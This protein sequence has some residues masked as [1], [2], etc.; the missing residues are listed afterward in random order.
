MKTRSRLGGYSHPTEVV[1]KE[2]VRKKRRGCTKQM[3]RAHSGHAGRPR[4]HGHCSEALSVH[5][6]LNRVTAKLPLA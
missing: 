2:L 6:A 5:R 1:L 3:P 4:A